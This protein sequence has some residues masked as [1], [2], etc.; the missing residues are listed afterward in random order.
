MICA[1]ENIGSRGGSVFCNES[2]DL[3][4]ATGIRSISIKSNEEYDKKTLKWHKDK[5]CWFEDVRPIPVC[6]NWFEKV[7]SEYNDRYGK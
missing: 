1:G 6:E 4:D 7:W 2:P 3:S 5:A